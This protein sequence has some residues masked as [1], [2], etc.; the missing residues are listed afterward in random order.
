VAPGRSGVARLRFLVVCC[1]PVAAGVGPFLGGAWNWLGFA[2]YVGLYLV[3][4]LLGPRDVAPPL[5]RGGRLLD[6]LLFVQVPL[7]AVAWLGFLVSF[8]DTGTGLLAQ[9]G[10][11]G[12]VAARAS[13]ADL[14]GACLSFA[15]AI[16]IAGTVTA[17]ELVHRTRSPASLLA[18]RFLLAFIF[19]AAFSIEHVHGHHARVGTADDPATARRGE[20]LYRFIGRSTLQS[21][22]GAW[23]IERT[24]LARRGV[25]LWSWQNRNLRGI[26]LSLALVLATA[27]AAGAPA[28]VAFVLCCAFAKCMLEATNYVEHYGLVRVPGTPIGPRHSWDTA[29]PISAAGMFNLGRHAAHHV[30]ARPYWTLALTGQSPQL[31]NGLVA[32]VLLA[33][34]PPLWRRKMARALDRW[35]R[36]QATDAERALARAGA[37]P[38]FAAPANLP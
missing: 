1:V 32:S 35:D 27:A 4:D 5:A 15:V 11:A 26:G 2:V 19:D 7:L 18:G 38:A 6:A 37:P 12:A 20:T 33:A 17:H 21:F 14:V 8:S 31:P 3:W 22:R 30:A 9:R 16:S 10:W 28:T 25:P 23:Q 34:V 29:A 24:R 13:A 36:E